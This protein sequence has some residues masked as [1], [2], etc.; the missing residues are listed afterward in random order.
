MFVPWALAVATVFVP[1]AWT[2]YGPRAE[3]APTTIAFALGLALIDAAVA[4]WDA[5]RMGPQRAR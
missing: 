3:V 2:L 4:A 1:V 5:W